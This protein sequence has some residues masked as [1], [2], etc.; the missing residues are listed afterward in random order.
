MK[1]KCISSEG[2]PCRGQSKHLAPRLNM[3]DLVQEVEIYS[4]IDNKLLWQLL[5]MA[6]PLRSL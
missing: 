6:L 3:K 5:T 4:V 2:F 1:G